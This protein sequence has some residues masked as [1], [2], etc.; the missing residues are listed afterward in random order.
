MAKTSDALIYLPGI[1]GSELVDDRGN[2]VWGL[3]P[4]LIFRQALFGDVLERLELRPGDGIRA[5]RPVRFPVNLPLLTAME[6]Y[7]ALE[8]RLKTAALRPEAVRSFAYDWRKSIAVAAAELA[9]FARAHLTEWRRRW[10]ALPDDERKGPEPRL[11][12]VGHS[13]GGLVAS[14]FAAFGDDDEAVRRI[15]TLGTPFGGSLNAVNVLATGDALPMRLFARALRDTARTLPGLHELLARWECVADGRTLR[16]L[17]AADLVGIG[18]SRE[19]FDAASETMDGLQAA[20][21]GEAGARRPSVR[22]LVGTTQPTRQTVA[23]RDGVPTFFESI[24]DVDHRG[25]GTV[26]RFAAVPDDVEPSYLPQSHGALAKT[27]EAVE[28]VAAVL[29]ERKL[30]EFMAPRGVG[31]RAP[32]VVAVGEPFSIEIVDAQPGVGCQL[33]D[34]EENRLVTTALARDEG[35]VLRAT[36]NAPRPG[37]YRVAVAGGGFSPVERLVGA[38]G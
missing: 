22:C 3:K 36:F 10:R 2:V 8:A 27:Q 29:T 17:T 13:M 15:V 26:F 32:E 37:L 31:V 30:G 4:S 38:V 5:S 19:L 14:H 24:D 7:S 23:F 11:T 16:K 33:Q 9:P 21:R 34:A 20:L 35:G 12:L 28:F 1:M 25:D 18:A 6:P